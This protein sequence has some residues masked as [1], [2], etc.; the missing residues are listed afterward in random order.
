MA[1]KTKAPDAPKAVPTLSPET[2]AARAAKAADD[3]W[4]KAFDKANK[5]YNT[6]MSMAW[7]RYLAGLRADTSK[8]S[9]GKDYDKEYDR[10]RNLYLQ[11]YHKVTAEID[12]TLKK[13]LKAIDAELEKALA[14]K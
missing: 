5:D 1:K 3:E 4:E 2:V 7:N 11:T 12:A 8:K 10:E 14:K 13:T 6:G 9:A